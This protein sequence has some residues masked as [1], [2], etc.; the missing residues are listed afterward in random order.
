MEM[1]FIDSGVGISE[2]GKKNLFTDFNKLEENSNMN[3]KGTGLGLSICKMI[4]EKFGG[5]VEVDSEI[6]KG[7]EFKIKLNL[8]CTMDISSPRF[9]DSIDSP[10]FGQRHKRRISFTSLDSREENFDFIVKHFDFPI[11][12]HLSC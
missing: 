10:G 1:C 3:A 8:K 9:H 6:N 7:C 11:V 12:S 4:V 2:E 5:S